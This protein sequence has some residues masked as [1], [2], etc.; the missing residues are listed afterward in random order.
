MKIYLA[1]MEGITGYVYRTLFEKHF[2]GADKY[3]TPFISA[4]EKLG[5]KIVR[6]ILPE[7]NEGMSLVPQIMV[8]TL[9]ETLKLHKLLSPYGYD[10]LN[11]NAGCPS[12]TVVSK[13]RGSGLLRK[14]Y[15]FDD[16]LE[17]I[18]ENC[19]CKFSVKTRLGWENINEW[20]CLARMYGRFPFSEVIIHARVRQEF[21][22]GN[23]HMEAMDIAREY[24]EAPMCYNGDIRTKE[25]VECLMDRYPWVDSV[26]IGRGILAD[27][28]LFEKIKGIKSDK[29]ENVRVYDFMDDMY[30]TYLNLFKSE[31]NTLF[32]MKELWGFMA[33]RYPD[34]EK[35]LKTIR[36]TK[37]ISEYKSAVKSIL[38]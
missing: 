8:G 23:A 14:P 32:H 13:N 27:P 1:P 20:D 30:E 37:K 15:E 22:N 4:H 11:I 25:D 24:I 5:N 17:E 2:A 31:I 34:K 16:L 10:E 33:H 3:F 29:D 7:N 12:G 9:E 36:K 19:P 21:Y 35:E 6:E 38:L 18:F 28:C 26:M